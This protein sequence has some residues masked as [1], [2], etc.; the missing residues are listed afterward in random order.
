MRFGL[1]ALLGTLSPVDTIRLDQ[2]VVGLF[3][4]PVA[5]GLYVVAQAFTNLPRVVATSIGVVAYP[6]VAAEAERDVARRAMWRFFALGVVTS[7]LVVAGL[8]VMTGRLVTL[9]FGAEFSAAIPIAHILLLGTFFMAARR[10]LNDGV[11]GLG[12][13]GLGTIAEVF[14]WIVLL[15]GLAIF[16][17][18][19]GASGVALALAIAWAA[20][21]LLLILL[22]ADATRAPASRAERLA[23]ALRY[24]L[25]LL[26]RLDVQKALG[27]AGVA[28]LA[29]GG[30]LAAA[31]VPQLAVYLVVLLLAGLV[32][33]FGRMALAQHG[34]RFILGRPHEA[35]GP[36]PTEDSPDEAPLAAARGLYYGGVLLMGLLTIRA[37]GQVTFSDVLFLFSFLI[38]AAE[39]AILRRR[40]PIRLPFLLLIGIAIFAVGG[41]LS[42]FESLQP[43]KS[44]GIVGRLIFLTV[45]WFWLGSV[46]LQ[47][48][49]HV[50][51]ALGFWVASAAICGAGAV[52]QILGGN[53]PGGS[54]EGGRATGFTSQPN[55]LGGMMAIA[56][57]PALMLASRPGLP[58]LRRASSYVALLMIAAGLVL[59]ASV[60]AVFAAIA[61]IFI[62]LAFQRTSIDGMLVF[63]TLAACV[64]AMTAFQTIR[65]APSPLDRLHTT[66]SNSSLASGGTQLGSVD[67]RIRTY[68]M[69]ARHIKQDPFVGVGLDLASVTRPFGVEN[70][71]YDVHNLLIGL[72]YKTG[73]IGL[74]GMLLALLSIFRS[75]WS[76]MVESDSRSEWQIAVALLSSTL[77]FVVFAMS[78]PVLFS[79]FGW[80][81][82]A[83]MLALRAVQGGRGAS[84][85]AGRERAGS[86]PGGSG[87]RAPMTAVPTRSNS[88]RTT[89]FFLVD[90]SMTQAE[91]R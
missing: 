61:G 12:K 39:Y 27:L 48:R 24:R 6:H 35:S 50:T 51:R 18:R 54:F 83:L 72:W 80:I 15:P 13:P 3:L 55:D 43:L 82:A 62:W 65:G 77:A 17:P 37:G 90:R 53:I 4:N 84:R 57:V 87:S 74:V 59:S 36:A 66:T 46:V 2:A 45:F 76:A 78:E 86:A 11:N 79:R 22:A 14:S 32:F 1:K 7:A 91:H 73:L 52:L 16:L 41:F 28:A 69:A 29:V 34:G 58:A 9:F 70:Y 19:Y 31:L 30:G 25:S 40:V 75:G 42:T 85:C 88:N 71:E 89:W 10:V 8:E 38:A 47:R 26:P 60:G 5:L 67:Q 33:A 23:E 68:R 81:P 63:A 56:F 49:E 20:S 64:V 21:L 44:I